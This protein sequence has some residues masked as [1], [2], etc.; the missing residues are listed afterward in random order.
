MWNHIYGS[1]HSL[2]LLYSICFCLRILRSIG[3]VL[4]WSPCTNTALRWRIHRQRRAGSVT[5]WLVTLIVFTC[6]DPPVHPITPPPRI[7][8]SNAWETEPLILCYLACSTWNMRSTFLNP[9][10]LSSCRT[11]RLGGCCLQHMHALQL[12]WQDFGLRW[13]LLFCKIVNH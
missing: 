11:P 12:N 6:W 3:K 2:T 10:L 1:K 13:F 4:F 8:R 9:L 5:S 7:T